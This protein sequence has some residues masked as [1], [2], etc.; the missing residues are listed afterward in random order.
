MGFWENWMNINFKTKY[1]HFFW[2]GGTK[3]YQIFVAFVLVSSS[4]ELFKSW[5]PVLPKYPP[6]NK[7][8]ISEYD[9]LYIIKAFKLNINLDNAKGFFFVPKAKPRNTKLTMGIIPISYFNKEHILRAWN[10]NEGII[11]ISKS[12]PYPAKKYEM[13][14]IEICQKISQK[15]YFTKI[16]YWISL[17]YG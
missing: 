16:I 5:S 6:R 13:K 12:N 15:N 1:W 7:N 10:E 9:V 14:I 2:G 8:Y 17:I 3:F 4:F 11:P